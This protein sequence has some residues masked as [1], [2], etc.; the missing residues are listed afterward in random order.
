MFLL[1][2]ISRKKRMVRFLDMDTYRIK[3]YSVSEIE[4]ILRS[5]KEVVNMRVRIKNKKYIV[6]PDGMLE[7]IS[8]SPKYFISHVDYVMPYFQHI[9]PIAYKDGF[10]VIEKEME[11]S[12]I[13]Y[14]IWLNGYALFDVAFEDLNA[15]YLEMID[16]ES[17][18]WSYIQ[19]YFYIDDNDKWKFHVSDLL[20]SVPTSIDMEEFVKNGK[21]MSRL[22]FTKH[23]I[24]G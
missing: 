14:D 22:S 20:G 7:I 1:V 18:D 17:V 15:Y 9:Y 8:K 12:I 3:W 5:K 19:N 23:C 24:L 21:P 11:Y 10:I 4:N 2:G 6:S 16:A 13:G